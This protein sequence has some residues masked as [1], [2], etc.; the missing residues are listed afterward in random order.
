M[1]DLLVRFSLAVPVAVFLAVAP[2]SRAHE[3]DRSMH[4]VSFQVEQSREVA[5]DQVRAVIGITEE[6]ADAAALANRVNTR[7]ERA[8]RKAR[9]ASGVKVESGAY[10]T[11]PVYEKGRIRRWRAS[12]DIV[13]EGKDATA[14]G[15]LVG[16]LQDELLLRSMDFSVSPELRRE[17]EDGLVVDA[18]A[19]FGARATLVVENLDASSYD[20]VSL[21]I[22]TGSGAVPRLRV[23]QAEMMGASKVAAPALEAGTS[24]VTIRVNATIELD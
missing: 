13:L 11:H 12:Q 7:M 1:S 19:A 8:L 2:D 16:E 14:V 5:N 4:R 9:R 10:R 15:T 22:D 21:S 6:D 3:A 17:V 24:R 18:L 23:R 20:L